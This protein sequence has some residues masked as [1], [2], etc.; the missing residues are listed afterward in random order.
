MDKYLK[1]KKVFESIEDKENAIAMSKYM[2][3][4]F[5]FYGLPTPKRKKV[6]NDFIKLEKK[7]KVID[8]EFLDKCYEDEHREF[9]YLV[10]DYLL[11]TKQ[12][13]SF[14]DITKIKKYIIT[15]SCS[16]FCNF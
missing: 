15:K 10:Y 5:V 7:N 13:I 14:E 9:Q 6:Y 2:R 3:N 1:I 8:W 12:Y 4:M 16:I 11:A